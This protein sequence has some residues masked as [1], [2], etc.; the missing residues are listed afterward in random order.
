MDSNNLILIFSLIGFGLF[1]YNYLL[2]ILNKYKPKLLVDDQFTKPQAFHETPISRAGGI[3]IF[4]SLLIVYLNFLLFK[5]IIFLE[6]LSFSTLFFTLG[7][8]DDI[9]VNISAKIRLAIMI[10]FLI[11]LINFN[12]FYI[13]KTGIEILDNWLKNS[14]IL[15]HV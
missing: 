14:E 5:N 1:F 15:Q 7:F 10:V 12:N 13:G 6:Y 4:F 9:K 11:I 2:L 8:L 3:C